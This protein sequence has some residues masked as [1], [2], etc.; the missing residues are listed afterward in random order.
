MNSSKLIGNQAAAQIIMR[1]LSNHTLPHTLL[2][3][4]Q[5]GVGKSILAKEVAEGLMGSSHIEKI[6]KQIHPDLTLLH[7]EGK[8]GV[9]SMEQ[10][11]SLLQMVSLSPFEAKVKVFILQEVDKLST[12][13]SNALLKTLEEASSDTYFILLTDQIEKLLETV[14]SRCYKVRF[15][16]IPSDLIASFLQEHTTLA[17]EE[18]RNIA[19][20]SQGSLARA[21]WLSEVK[22]EK[23]QRFLTELFSLNLPQDYS[24]FIQ[25][26]AGTDAL[27]EDTNAETILEEI[28]EWYRD[29]HAFKY[30]APGFYHSNH[31]Q[32]LAKKA[33]EPLPSLE[34]ILEVFIQAQTA[35]QRNIKLPVV[36]EDMLL[37]LA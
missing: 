23:L 18:V 33:K 3:H 4:G 16:P 30:Q 25:L 11:R 22:S 28:L 31:M 34:R 12:I 19:D 1:M 9:Y 6:R 2:F 21:Q 26:M 15:F 27:L 36:I 24:P 8:S 17:K 5:N 29:L 20:R 13:C 10:M 7:P 32:L 35:L 37:Q 14:T